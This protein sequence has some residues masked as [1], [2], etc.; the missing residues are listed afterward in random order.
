MSKVSSLVCSLH[1]G[2]LHSPASLPCGH[3]FCQSC[4]QVHLLT[5]RQCPSC[6][7]GDLE[8]SSIVP[9][10]ALDQ[11]LNELDDRS[12][13][14]PNELQIIQQ[15][16]SSENSRMYKTA[17]LNTHVIWKRIIGQN[18]SPLNVALSNQF[19]LIQ[20][21]DFP[22]NIVRVYGVTHSP[23]GIVMEQ[24]DC[25]IQDKFDIGH[26]F[27]QHEVCIIVKDMLAGLRSLHNHEVGHCN[28]KASNVLINEQNGLIITAKLSDLKLLSGINAMGKNDT[29][30]A[31]EIVNKSKRAPS[32]S[33]DVY[34]LGVLLTGLLLSTDPYVVI[35]SFVQRSQPHLKSLGFNQLMLQ[36]LSH[37]LHPTPSKRPTVAEVQARIFDAIEQHYINAPSAPSYNLKSVT[38]EFS[39]EN[40]YPSSNSQ[41]NNLKTLPKQQQSNKV[42]AR[43]QKGSFFKPI[44]CNIVLI[45]L[46]LLLLFGISFIVFEHVQSRN[47][48]KFLSSS[49]YSHFEVMDPNNS[50][51]RLNVLNLFIVDL[52]LEIPGFMINSLTYS[53]TRRSYVLEISKQNRQWTRQTL[54]IDAS[55]TYN[56]HGAVISL[57]NTL[58]S[59]SFNNIETHDLYDSEFLS[60]SLIDHVSSVLS[61]L[62]HFSGVIVSVLPSVDSFTITIQKGVQSVVLSVQPV[63]V[64]SHQAE[65]IQDAVHLLSTT[66]FVDL[67][68]HNIDNNQQKIDALTNYV[69]TLLTSYHGSF[70]VSIASNRFYVSF[71]YDDARGSVTI[72][73]TFTL[74]QEATDVQNAIDLLNSH[75]F[76]GIEV[77]D[78]QVQE[79]RYSALLDEINTVLLVFETNSKILS[80]DTNLQVIVEVSKG[81]AVQTL[82]LTPIYV[83]SIDGQL[84]E[85]AKTDILM[86]LPDVLF[87]ED[88]ENLIQKKRVLEEEIEAI[89]ASH[90]VIFH[91]SY[92]YE[93]ELF[94][95]SVLSNDAVRL[96]FFSSLAF[97][98]SHEDRVYRAVG[99]I[100][101]HSY[102]NMPSAS[103]ESSK[104]AAIRSRTLEITETTKV[105][106]SVLSAEAATRYMVTVSYNSVFDVVEITVFFPLDVLEA[107]KEQILQHLFQCL[108]VD[109]VE[110][111]SQRISVL[112]LAIEEFI[113]DPTVTVK[114]DSAHSF[115]WYS[116]SLTKA[117]D[118]VIFGLTG[119]TFVARDIKYAD[120]FYLG[121]WSQGM[122]VK[123]GR[124][125]TFGNGLHGQLAG[126]RGI[127]GSCTFSS[128][129]WPSSPSYVTNI[130]QLALAEAA[131]FLLL[132]DGTIRVAGDGAYS[133]GAP[134]TSRFDTPQ[135]I[136]GLSSVDSVYTGYTHYAAISSGLVWIWGRNSYGKLGL[137]HTSNSNTP[138][139]LVLPN[140]VLVQKVALGRDHSLVLTEDGE[141]Y[142][143]G[144]NNFG[145]L[146]DST[147]FDRHSPTLI[148]GLEDV[149]DIA[150]G[151]DSSYALTS[152][153]K[154][155]SWGRNSEGQLCIG[156]TTSHPRFRPVETENFSPKSIF[157]KEHFV[158]VTSTDGRLFGCGSNSHHQLSSDHTE[159]I[160][161]PS[162]VTKFSTV[163]SVAVGDSHVI[164]TLQNGQSYAWGS[165]NNNRLGFRHGTLYPKPSPVGCNRH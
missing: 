117:Y 113:D 83:L 95:C 157:S 33:M 109:K 71:S 106:V 1:L 147:N 159:N 150:A 161:S 99:L 114:L 21:L 56:D 12:A 120:A 143:F 66:S 46:S 102:E 132:T 16:T 131:S 156:S 88:P 158:L 5:S 148:D 133:I 28:L 4:I 15:L 127:C 112:K 19:S 151:A 81:G 162:R 31:P 41:L 3:S 80:E 93:F 14:H 29:Y 125:W 105:S 163:K 103:T 27:T 126:G 67:P 154:M 64:L 25:S 146:G 68:V 140:N 165:N 76:N 26:S 129:T 36:M 97:C 54:I 85:H 32:L 8:T 141:V 123:N 94:E 35:R 17:L 38:V 53:S 75:S 144:R 58:E 107:Y 142:S 22:R 130:K 111:D 119:C 145:Q 79:L 164:A 118:V 74:S 87:V 59:S 44:H 55:F 65:S 100:L 82:L 138:V 152:R 11:V 78:L 20:A 2:L 63:F 69:N 104:L 89:L 42:G 49:D 136:S 61:H 122:A 39:Q 128:F 34:S 47:V 24:L 160:S 92:N 91:V 45:I 43:R 30:V 96:I 23:P 9:N 48:K 135:I 62:S 50:E 98:C 153:G 108:E 40:T 124:L 70:S 18:T 77:S 60:T 37:M 121:V 57:K 115:N 134:S 155:Y 7:R 101:S 13:I 116:I 84:V 90:S 73:A 51:E 52:L 72:D 137:G 6:N 139:Q 86:N 10:A 110:D 149:I